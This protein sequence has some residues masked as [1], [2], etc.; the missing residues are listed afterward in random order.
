MAKLS[1]AEQVKASKEFCRLVEERHAL[2][3]KHPDFYPFVDLY[4]PDYLEAVAKA[5]REIAEQS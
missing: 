3:I 4:A 2:L 1:R 5:L